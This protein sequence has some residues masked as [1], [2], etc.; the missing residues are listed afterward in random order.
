MH[1][2]ARAWPARSY[3]FSTER[4]AVQAFLGLWTSREK[5]FKH[6]IS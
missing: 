1:L 6:S 4:M 5:G 2:G 3:L